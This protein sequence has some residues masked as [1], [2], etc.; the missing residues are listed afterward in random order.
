MASN[1][2]KVMAE[3]ATILE[4]SDCDPVST[5]KIIELFGRVCLSAATA[6]TTAPEQS[7]SVAAGPGKYVPPTQDVWFDEEQQKMADEQQKIEDMARLKS[8][9][10]GLAQ[11]VQELTEQVDRLTTVCL[12]SDDEDS[13]DD[14]DDCSPIPRCRQEAAEWAKNTDEYGKP[15]PSEDDDDVDL[16]SSDKV[17]RRK[18]AADVRHLHTV[19]RQQIEEA[20]DR[21]AAAQR[22]ARTAKEALAEL[23]DVQNASTKTI[24]DLQREV[25]DL[26]SELL[27][28]Q[29]QELST[30]EEE[31]EEEEDEDEDDMVLDDEIAPRSAAETRRRRLGTFDPKDP[32]GVLRDGIRAPIESDYDDDKEKKRQEEVMKEFIR[33]KRLS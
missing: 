32:F 2:A 23:R 11:R 6:V 20:L 30:S 31:E 27:V 7:R 13:D 33:I 22:E 10:D 12:K 8:E 26:K 17:F 3:L 29:A 28:A 24:A 19:A 15:L 9:R 4:W 21:Q 25:D 14:D 5:A 1:P 18:T 16:T